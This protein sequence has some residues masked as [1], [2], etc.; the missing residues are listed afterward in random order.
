MPINAPH[1][2]L[3]RLQPLTQRIEGELRRPR[4]LPMGGNPDAQKHGPVNGP[5]SRAGRQAKSTARRSPLSR[6]LVLDES[7]RAA[8]RQIAL[9]CSRSHSP[10]LVLDL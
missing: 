5:S 1:F 3:Q 9:C 2:P 8:N 4:Q 6:D 10:R 7:E